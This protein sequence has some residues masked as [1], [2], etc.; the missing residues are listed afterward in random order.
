MVWIS[1]HSHP[2]PWASVTMVLCTVQCSIC[3]DHWPPG[4]RGCNELLSAQQLPLW[5]ERQT[6]SHE[7]GCRHRANFQLQAP[8]QLCKAQPAPGAKDEALSWPTAPRAR[9]SRQ[10]FRAH[11]GPSRVRRRRWRTHLGQGWWRGRL[12][13]AW[14]GTVGSGPGQEGTKRGSSEAAKDW[15]R[16][17]SRGYCRGPECPSRGRSADI[18]A[19]PSGPLGPSVAAAPHLGLKSWKRPLRF[20]A[21]NFPA[22]ASPAPPPWP[23]APQRGVMVPAPPAAPRLSPR[24]RARPR[25]RGPACARRPPRLLGFRRA[26]AHALRLHSSGAAPRACVG[27]LWGG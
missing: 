26:A 21:E 11:G 3:S 18:R 12:R 19:E 5:M 24:L 16:R 10:E 27:C 7:K 25:D 23:P 6:S 17:G 2:G 4:N 20:M 15:V 9:Q 8:G 13:R 1:G 14:A 22:A